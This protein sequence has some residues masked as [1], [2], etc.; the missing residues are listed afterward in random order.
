MARKSGVGTSIWL[1]LDREIDAVGTERTLE[2][3]IG[4]SVRP[5]YSFGLRYVREAKQTDGKR[6]KE[7][8]EISSDM[9]FRI[10]KV[11]KEITALVAFLEFWNVEA[12]K[13]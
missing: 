9:D 8:R 6:E 5:F 10:S 7:E 11:Y 13:N 12:S 4:Y 2:S 3:G 1:V